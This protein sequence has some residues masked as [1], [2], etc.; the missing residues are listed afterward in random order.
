MAHVIFAVTL[1]PGTLARSSD[2]MSLVNALRLQVNGRLD[3]TNL[4]AGAVVTSKIGDSQVTRAK[5]ADRVINPAK[6]D[7]SFFASNAEVIAGTETT[8]GVNS[9]GVAAAIGDIDEIPT[10]TVGTKLVIPVS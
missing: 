8:K 4:Q 5:L 9:A 7:P 10:L 3:Q 1:T 2:V 6:V